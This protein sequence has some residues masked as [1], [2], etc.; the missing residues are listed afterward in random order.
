MTGFKWHLNV[1]L[2]LLA[3]C[4]SG[5]GPGGDYSILVTNPAQ[6][7]ATCDG[8]AN[9]PAQCFGVNWTAN[10]SANVAH[11]WLA[12]AS[13]WQ[14]V[15]PTGTWCVHVPTSVPV[16]LLTN[17]SAAPGANNFFQ[18]YVHLSSTAPSWTSNGGQASPGPAC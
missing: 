5:T 16:V 18:S 10:D 13:G 11:G 12:P 17:V 6:R 7:L 9:Q 4:G 8:S 14:N 2:I 3:A 15:P 1:F